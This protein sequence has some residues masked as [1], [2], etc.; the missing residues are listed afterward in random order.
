MVCSTAYAAQIIKGNEL[1][2]L[3]WTVKITKNSYADALCSASSLLFSLPLKSTERLQMFC[4]LI[5][6]A[7][8]LDPEGDV[9]YLLGIK[10]PK[11]LCCKSCTETEHVLL[12]CPGRSNVSNT[13]KS[14]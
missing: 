5:S 3:F 13:S 1:I 2:L 9:I 11:P 14:G 7:Q 12:F 4:F 6:A 8:I 10:D